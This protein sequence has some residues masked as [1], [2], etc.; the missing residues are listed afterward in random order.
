MRYALAGARSWTGARGGGRSSLRSGFGRRSTRVPWE[1][2]RVPPEDDPGLP[3]W[4]DGALDPIGRYLAA[5]AREGWM[6]GATWWVQAGESVR[7]GAVEARALWP[8]RE[9][10]TEDTA[11]DL[12]S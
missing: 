8:R 12:A 11:Y 9:G 7:R 6:P 10:A 2:R 4:G 5:R 1:P 3:A